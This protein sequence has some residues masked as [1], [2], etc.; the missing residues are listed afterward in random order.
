MDKGGALNTFWSSFGLPAYNEA[1]V[2]T[3]PQA[4]DFP[5]ITYRTMMGSFGQ[6]I[7]LNGSIWYRSSSWSDAEAKASEISR[8]IS[9]AGV[10]VDYDDGA[11]W[12][13]R[14]DPF[15]YNMGDESDDAIKR[16][17]INIDVEF[18][19]ED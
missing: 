11:L 5:Y 9:R 6:T 13:Q 19:S 4:P 18:I 14:G 12:I 7:P 3:G 2:P 8:A 10:F 1:S 15:S 17:N 16:I